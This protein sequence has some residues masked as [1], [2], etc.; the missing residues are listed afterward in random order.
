MSDTKSIRKELNEGNKKRF[1]EVINSLYSE[2]L[3]PC[4]C[5][6]EAEVISFFISNIANRK[7]YF[8]RCSKCKEPR[9]HRNYRKR[10]KAIRDWNNEQAENQISK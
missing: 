5:G 6:G 1:S 10:E 7:H 3:R 8:V 2:E 4:K 9:N